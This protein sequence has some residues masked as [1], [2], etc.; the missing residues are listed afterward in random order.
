VIIDPGISWGYI[1]WGP[2]LLLDNDVYGDDC[3]LCAK[4]QINTFTP[5]VLDQKYSKIFFDFTNDP[6]PD[7][8][9]DKHYLLERLQRD[10]CRFQWRI[11][12]SE[13]HSKAPTVYLPI[14]V[15]AQT[16]YTTNHQFITDRKY[17]FS[18]LNG[19]PKWFRLRIAKFLKEHLD[20][21]DN[22]IRFCV[23]GQ[24]RILVEEVIKND[25]SFSESQVHQFLDHMKNL[26][27]DHTPQKIDLDIQHPAY[28]DSFVNIVT[29]TTLDGSFISEKT[30][31]PLRAQQFFIIA[32]PMGIIQHL[33]D[34]GFD[35]F[36]DIFYDHT[37]DQE[38]DWAARLTKI[39]NLVK[40]I[41]DSYW[42]DLYHQNLD[43]LQSNRER[44]HSNGFRNHLLHPFLSAFDD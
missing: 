3:V 22:L 26:P 43:R 4:I 23:P 44:F 16:F 14:F 21:S 9:H 1:P 12:T 29:E 5:D 10:D 40:Q 20:D 37:Y 19:A 32:G 18:C 17:N 39:E 11:L 33:R 6:F 27:N 35:V 42:Q 13:F 24:R 38:P 34:L 25:S 15:L 30:C 28:L 8:S 36:D 41:K 2:N 7:H 31:K